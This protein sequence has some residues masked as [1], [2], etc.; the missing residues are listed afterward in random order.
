MKGVHTGTLP[1]NT[2]TSSIPCCV[3]SGLQTPI[4]K[5]QTQCTGGTAMAQQCP[6][7]GVVGK[8][9]IFAQCRF[10]F[11][12]EA[13]NSSAIVLQQYESISGSKYT[14]RTYHSF[15]ACQGQGSRMTKKEPLIFLP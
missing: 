14:L 9:G 15:F 5:L 3:D 7:G 6:G 10:F 1:P 12:D 13:A 4:Q 11:F 8:G 2:P